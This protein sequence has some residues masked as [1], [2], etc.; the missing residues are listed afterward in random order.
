MPSTAMPAVD[1]Q[2]SSTQPR[3]EQTALVER[4]R[5]RGMPLLVLGFTGVL[6]IP[7]LEFLAPHYVESCPYMA[8]GN[9]GGKKHAVTEEQLTAYDHS[10]HVPR[11]PPARKAP[12][13]IDGTAGVDLPVT[14][15]AKRTIFFG[16]DKLT[17]EQLCDRASAYGDD[18]EPTNHAM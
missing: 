2:A 9:D 10:T 15:P 13:G 18:A 3:V 14:P 17:L 4:S 1:A 7:L 8:A 16:V 5:R 6:I 12:N 11:M